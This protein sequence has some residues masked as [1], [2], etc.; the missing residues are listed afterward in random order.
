M[1]ANHLPSGEN[2]ALSSSAALECAVATVF[3]VLGG[4]TIE[5]VRKAQLCQR[6]ENELV[7]DGLGHPLLPTP[8]VEQG[9]H[10]AVSQSY[11]EVVTHLHGALVHQHGEQDPAAWLL[12]GLHHDASRRA[13]RSSLELENLRLQVYLTEQ[14]VD[15]EALLGRLLS[16]LSD[17]LPLIVEEPCDVLIPSA[18]EHQI[19]AE[20]AQSFGL[21]GFFSKPINED[22]FLN[23]I[24]NLVAETQLAPAH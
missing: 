4:W 8:L 24:S 16:I 21:S 5:P 18:L 10:L 22:L 19:T 2:D 9:A 17:G 11:Q 20:N 13:L 6:A 15:A 1:K 14:L 12:L 3:E 23:K 7:G